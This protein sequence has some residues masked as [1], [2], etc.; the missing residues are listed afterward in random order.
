MW[1]RRNGTERNGTTP[2]R[3]STM[4][5]SEK[6]KE[7]GLLNSRVECPS[8]PFHSLLHSPSPPLSLTTQILTNQKK[9]SSKR[10]WNEF[11]SS[12]H[13][14]FDVSMLRVC[15]KV[16]TPLLQG[17]RAEQSSRFRIN[18]HT[19]SKEWQGYLNLINCLGVTYFQ[20]KRLLSTCAIFLGG[21]S[22]RR[23]D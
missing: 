4:K 14:V 5:E 18:R 10:K 15:L 11:S 12:L 20:I 23:P 7:N 16:C 13:K 2:R 9:K 8:I 1:R 22:Y 17:I 3:P 6:M 19:I 21:F